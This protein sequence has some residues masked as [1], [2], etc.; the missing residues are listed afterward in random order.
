MSGFGYEWV[1]GVYS[2]DGTVYDESYSPT[3]A[4]TPYES[5]GSS[6]YLEGFQATAAAYSNWTHTHHAHVHNL[7]TSTTTPR[8]RELSNAN[9]AQR[10][11]M[12]TPST[13]LVV[14]SH[15][16]M[17]TCSD[18]ARTNPEVESILTDL[19]PPPTE[20]HDSSPENATVLH[21]WVQ[22]S[23]VTTSKSIKNFIVDASTPERRLFFCAWD[24]CQHPLGFPNKP[25]LMTHVRSLH[26]QEKP[27][28]CTTC[29]TL[30][31]RK[32]DA[33]RHVN[34]ANSGKRYECRM[35]L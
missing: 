11:W 14:P 22:L 18:S 20:N 15:D 3:S 32:Q 5:R 1:Q 23:P 7:L 6:S 2:G 13:P 12:M 8:E 21:H 28:L 4:S 24:G 10:D 30:F 35:W 25:Q 34:T 17:S 9:V 26:L 33:I 27:F 16:A 19:I 29:R 31:A